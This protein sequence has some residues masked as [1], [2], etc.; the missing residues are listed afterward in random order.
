MAPLLVHMRTGFGCLGIMPA[1][2]QI[3][4]G[5]QAAG[6]HDQI[7][8]VVLHVDKSKWV[9]WKIEEINVYKL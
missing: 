7:P 9:N 5:F 8:H 4:T 3:D 1:E 2:D 6:L